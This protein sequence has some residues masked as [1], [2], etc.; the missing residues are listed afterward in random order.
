V[1]TDEWDYAFNEFIKLA[2]LF[3]NRQETNVLNSDQFDCVIH[4]NRL[5]RP[6]ICC[7]SELRCSVH[8]IMQAISVTLPLA[9]EQNLAEKLDDFVTD[10]NRA[11][12]IVPSS[13][14]SSS[15]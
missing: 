9:F 12:Q 3:Q 6:A 8:H 14:S 10:I 2:V 11:L 4:C 15:S 1:V 13:S 7:L 5:N